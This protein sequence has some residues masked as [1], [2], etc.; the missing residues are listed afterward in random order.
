MLTQI[1]QNNGICVV[2][3]VR[4]VNGIE[5]FK[6]FIHSYQENPGGIEHELLIVFKGF[7]DA[8]DKQQHLSLLANTPYKTVDISDL[9]V[10]ITA[11]KFVID[12]YSDKYQYFCFMNSFSEIQDNTWLKKMYE[13]IK[14]PN[15]GIVG[16]TGCWNSNNKNARLWFWNLIPEL[17]TKKDI[18]SCKSINVKQYNNPLTLKI[19]TYWE[20]IIYLLRRAYK[21]ITRLF[22]Y[23][24]FPN[25]HIR[26][27]V[28]MVSSEIMKAI[29][30]PCIKGKEEAYKFE[31]AKKSLTMQIIHLNKRALVVGKN[32]I[33][34]D[35][36]EWHKSRTFLSYD[37]ENLLVS[38]NQTQNYQNADS[39]KRQ[40][41]SNIAWGMN[42]C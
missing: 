25:Y 23:P 2:H 26:T 11:Y 20:V 36:E 18:K 42:L 8:I 29:K 10:D 33:G 22:L 30:I 31:S 28:F 6:R 40:M 9:G 19:M 35:K 4:A 14:K 15:V 1:A 24:P 12:Q 39:K 27:N 37:Q 38:D 16:A 41:L 3:L 21:E 17:L 5:P 32:G 34:Y 7:N 13:N